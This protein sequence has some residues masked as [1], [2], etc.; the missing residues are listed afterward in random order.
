M[1]SYRTKHCYI[2]HF[3]LHP[4]WR[5]R[6]LAYA[7]DSGSLAEQLQISLS[8]EDQKEVSAKVIWRAVNKVW[9][10]S[11]LHQKQTL[12]WLG[13]LLSWSTYELAAL[14]HHMYY[15]DQNSVNWKPSHRV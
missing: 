8:A 6:E 4:S 11:Q 2:T 15:K 14:Q 3:L 9:G 13:L 7:N 5:H 10:R 1:E 12:S